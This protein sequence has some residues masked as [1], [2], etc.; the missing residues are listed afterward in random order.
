MIEGRVDVSGSIVNVDRSNE[1]ANR[2]QSIK[3][4]FKNGNNQTVK[5]LC[6]ELLNIDANCYEA[7]IYG[8]LAEGWQSSIENN[9][10]MM[11][12]NDLQRAVE[13][14]RQIEESD[15]EFT[16]LCIMPM[17]EMKKIASAMFRT[18]KNY[19]DTQSQRC[20]KYLAEIRKAE[21]EARDYIGNSGAL[22]IVKERIQNYKNMAI[23]TENDRV[24]TY[25]NGC[26]IVC[27]SVLNVAMKIIN[28]I[29]NEEDVYPEFFDELESF[30]TVC[31]GYTTTA[32]AVKLANSIK[33]YLVGAK[34]KFYNKQKKLKEERVEKYWK[35]HADEKVAYDSELK[36]LKDEADKYK[37]PINEID[38]ALHVLQAQKDSDLPSDANI[39]DC[40]EKIEQL[41]KE[42]ASLGL[43]KGKEKKV[44]QDRI[45]K[46]E[47]ELVRYQEKR[48]EE[49]KE[50]ENRIDSQRRILQ[51]KG[52]PLR[53]KL[54]EINNRIE[55]ITD[56]LNRDR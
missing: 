35:E 18:Y 54:E 46:I 53:R 15:K 56:E 14:I 23:K 51:E 32:G 50:R 17:Q 20:D 3:N 29:H 26:G 49:K 4:E 9:R 1:I 43:L 33:G 30:Y 10:L 52:K 34:D 22:K 12:S 27:L 13:V 5:G 7:I 6:L 39:A 45:D 55:K 31:A 2:L 38:K 25:N 42:K 36:A 19:S 47:I 24:S 44:L 11:T 37:K 40:K 28:N 8:G 48:S 21:T 41:E 16:K